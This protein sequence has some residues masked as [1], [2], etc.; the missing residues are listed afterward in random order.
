MIKKTL[1]IGL[2]G[3]LVSG[4][5]F[6]RNVG[7][8][9]TTSVSCV[10]DTIH[11]QV[12]V[13]F[14]LERARKMIADLQPEIER[15]M[16]RI[17]KEEVGV[18]ELTRKLDRLVTRQDK[19]HSDVQRLAADLQSG[20]TQFVYAGKRV[21]SRQE[22]ERDLARRFEL[23]KT[24]DETIAN[25]RRTVEYRHAGLQ[26]GR[27][28]LDGMLA[29]Q[30]QLELDVESLVAR[31]TMLEV[32]QTAS[33][34]KI[35]DSHLART[36]ELVADIRT[37]LQV[38]EKVLDSSFELEV[39]QIEL[40]EPVGDD[41]LAQICILLRRHP[42]AGLRQPAGSRAIGRTGTVRAAAHS[43][44]DIVQYWRVGRTA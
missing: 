5:L 17:A 3:L 21:W 24:L 32:Q 33:N 10:R 8:Y 12:P 39:P 38:A 23:V 30:R 35:D 4:L 15:S 6:G 44:A 18:A 11:D 42:R 28:K 27:D 29:A 2:C 41:L 7:S 13:G 25:L 43:T 20:E 36:K 14:E 40:E 9:F 22:V 31:Q 1:G 34:M 26:A 19:G 16:Q 37:R